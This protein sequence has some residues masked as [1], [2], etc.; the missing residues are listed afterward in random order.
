MAEA[1][2][3]QQRK[4]SQPQGQAR[5][6][7]DRAIESTPARTTE[8][9]TEQGKT[10]IADQVV[11]K[12]AARAAREVSGVHELV[13]GG[14]GGTLSGL[15]QRMSSGETAGVQVEV[16][17]R[18]A[19]IDLAMTVDYGVSIPQVATAVRQNIMN[20]VQAMTGLRVREVNVDV[21]DLYLPDQQGAQQQ[22]SRV[23]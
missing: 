4:A 6:Q 5:E 11:A 23:D 9:I 17:Q 22:Q 1:Q 15:A 7:Q 3:E 8:L 13:P 18:E 16:G 12:I 21:A 14:V 19:A 20:R 2:Q 10:S